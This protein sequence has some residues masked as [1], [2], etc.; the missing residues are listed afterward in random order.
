MDHGNHDNTLRSLAKINSVRKLP[1]NRAAY[2]ATN[3][4]KR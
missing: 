1:K 3:D 4:G 2:L